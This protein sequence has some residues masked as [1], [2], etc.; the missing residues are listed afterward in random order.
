MNFLFPNAKIRF[1]GK[2]PNILLFFFAFSVLEGNEMFFFTMRKGKNVV[3]C[4]FSF[5]NLC[6]LLRGLKGNGVGRA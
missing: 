1:A 4:A 5:V 6:L 2:R 3:A